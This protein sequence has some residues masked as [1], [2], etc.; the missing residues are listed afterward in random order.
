MSG[1]QVERFVKVDA[2]SS[3]PADALALDVTVKRAS[4]HHMKESAGG[5]LLVDGANPFVV[6]RAS[7]ELNGSNVRIV[8]F[9][10]ICI[11]QEELPELKL[12]WHDSSR[13]W[14]DEDNSVKL[15][16][17]GGNVVF[18]MHSLSDNWMNSQN[19]KALR[20]DVANP[21]ACSAILFKDL[22]FLK[23]AR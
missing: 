21:S 19:I 13:A 22:R 4:Y 11:G 10:F 5:E 1:D 9:E 17:G 18:D 3:V 2:L 6:F 16:S 20:V 15:E 14:F 12:Y 23:D 8:A 7:R